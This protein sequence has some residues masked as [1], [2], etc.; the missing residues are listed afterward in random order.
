MNGAPPSPR[1]PGLLLVSHGEHAES[2]LKSARMILGEIEG[3]EAVGLP[4]D[5]SLE[6]LAGAVERALDRIG[7]DR[8]ILVLVDLFGGS[9]ANVAVRLLPKRPLRIVAGLNL[10]MVVE[11]A[12]RRSYGD[13][14]SLVEKVLEA[15]RRAVIDVNARVAGKVPPPSTA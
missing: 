9:C 7:P 11:F 14:D 12:L 13:I 4:T 15:G 10:A 1:P 3:A 2:A 5:G 8:P 6:D